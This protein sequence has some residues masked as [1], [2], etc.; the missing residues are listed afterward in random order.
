MKEQIILHHHKK[1]WCH[2]HLYYRFK[3]FNTILNV[4]SLM[5]TCCGLVIGPILQD[6]LLTALL[7]SVGMFV[8]GWNDLKKYPAKMDM[9]Q[10]AYSTH[11]KALSE[12]R[13]HMQGS[14]I[15]DVDS[16]LLKQ[17]T[18]EEVIID[19][20]P[21]IPDH[22]VFRYRQLFPSPKVMNQF[23][24][25]DGVDGKTYKRSTTLPFVNSKSS[26]QD[27]AGDLGSSS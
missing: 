11:A 9:T 26:C 5:V 2:R 16:F 19:F 22:I 14:P 15:E 12:L 8:K 7:A 1:W 23:L 25:M 6:V 27:N 10:F 24:G 17:Q 21:P 20:A 3:R 4:L 13:V 18:L